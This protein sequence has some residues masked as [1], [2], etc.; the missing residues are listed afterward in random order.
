MELLRIRVEELFPFRLGV[1]RPSRKLIHE[2]VRDFHKV[3]VLNEVENL[4]DATMLAIMDIYCESAWGPGTD[5]H[6]K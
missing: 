1:D 3:A 4:L 6:N 5:R 2:I